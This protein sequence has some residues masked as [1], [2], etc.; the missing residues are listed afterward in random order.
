M[1]IAAGLPVAREARIAVVV[2]P[3][4][5]PIVMGKAISRVKI[6]LPINGTSKEVVTELLCTMTVNRNPI[7]MPIEPWRPKTISKRFSAR[8]TTRDLMSLTRKYRA[9]NK[10]SKEKNK[11]KVYV[12]R[13]ESC[14]WFKKMFLISPTAGL[15]AVFIG[16]VNFIP[17]ASMK[18]PAKNVADFCKKP[19]ASSS[20]NIMA[21]Q[22]RLKK[23]CIVPPAKARRNSSFLVIC[24]SETRRQVTVV[25]I[26]AP[27]IIGTAL[28]MV[29]MPEATMPTTIEVV[30][31]EL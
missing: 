26:L 24:P 29:M 19:V 23:S 6:P 20:G 8:L 9:K 4:L 14:R 15:V 30:V 2:V 21:T 16:L 27:I 17:P 3:I 22:M 11:I 7:R 25:P 5:A 12:V 10:M 1:V 28:L 31:E 18:S 13:G